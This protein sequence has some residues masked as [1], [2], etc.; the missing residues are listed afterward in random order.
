MYVIHLFGVRITD[1]CSFFQI[2]QDANGDTEIGSFRTSGTSTFFDI[3][4]LD[5]STEYSVSFQLDL[6]TEMDEGVSLAA[7]TGKLYVKQVAV[8]M[9]IDD[10]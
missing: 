2:H 10:I 9:I 8:K 5:P 6:G 3:L 7:R 4:D 1:I